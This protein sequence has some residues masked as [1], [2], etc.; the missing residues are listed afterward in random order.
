MVLEYSDAV[1]YINSHARVAFAAAML[2]LIECASRLGDGD[3]ELELLDSLI[4]KMSAFKGLFD[5]TMI[6]LEKTERQITKVEE[7]INSF[8]PERWAEPS[9]LKGEELLSDRKAR[10]VRLTLYISNAVVEMGDM[11]TTM[12]E[13]YNNG[14]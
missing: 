5:I 10:Y 13:A 2:D 9:I 6:E 12:L 3:V 4:T 1:W 14:I 8:W 7:F 11:R